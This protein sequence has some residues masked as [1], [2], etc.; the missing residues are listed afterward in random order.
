MSEP[1]RVWQGCVI[2]HPTE[3]ERDEGQRA[4]IVVEPENFIA[5]GNDEAVMKMSR[6]IDN[7]LADESADR[8][9]V[10]VRPF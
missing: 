8:L 3:S 10:A 6:K 4:K 5:A 7:N 1:D 2:L 9:E